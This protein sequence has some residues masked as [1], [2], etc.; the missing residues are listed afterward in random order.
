MQRRVPNV[1][2]LVRLIGFRPTTPLLE[3]VDLVIAHMKNESKKH[4]VS[5]SPLI[6]SVA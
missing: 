2:K 5:T 3:I 6:A 4:C 1:D